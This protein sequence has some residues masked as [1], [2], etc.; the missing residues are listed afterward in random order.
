MNYTIV[1]GTN[2]DG[3]NSLILANYYKNK[4][5]EKGISSDIIDLRDLPHDFI[6]S[7]AYGKRTDEFRKIQEVIS[8]TDKFLFVIAEYNGS[9]PGVLKSFIDSC[10]FPD[11]FSGKKCAMVGLSAGK[12][13]NLRGLEHFSG[14]ANYV[15]MDVYHNKMYLP[16]IGNDINDDG[17]INTPQH[18]ALIES[19]IEGF[20]DF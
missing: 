7:N 20:I 14:V 10:D 12:F 11:S 4:F 8:K 3:S 17:E 9:F 5:L 18:V 1:S 19:Q 16:N 13:G 15:K 2:R 6:F